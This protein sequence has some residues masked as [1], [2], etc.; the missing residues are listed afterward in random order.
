MSKI[1]QVF[2][3]KQQKTVLHFMGQEFT[4]TMPPTEYGWHSKE[5]AIEDQVDNAFADIP[6]EILDL[7][8]SEVP[9]SGMVDDLIEQLDEYE[10]EAGFDG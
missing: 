3:A 5:R 9:G 2:E 4:L 8:T 7:L 10:R 1:T 6:D